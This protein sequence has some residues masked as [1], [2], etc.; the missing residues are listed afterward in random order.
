MITE[1]MRAKSLSLVALSILA[2]VFVAGL[3]SAAILSISNVNVPTSVSQNQGSFSIT[4]NLTNSGEAATISWANSNVSGGSATFSSFSVNSIANG[5]ATPVSEIVTVVVG[6]SPSFTGTISGIIEADPSGSGSSQSFNFSTQVTATQALT[7]TAIC[8]FDSG[9]TSNPDYLD[10]SIR[11]ITVTE[12]FGNDENW[13]PFDE[14]EVEIRV[15]NNGINNYDIDDISLEWGIAPDNLNDDWLFDFDE[16]DEFNLKDDDEDTFTITFKVDG[17]DLDMD[18]EDFAG[19][20]FNLVVRA[21]G[22]I[23]DEDNKLGGVEDTCTADSEAVSIDESN[24]VV[25]TNINVPET[26]QCG[27]T[28]TITADAWN[29]GNNQE[30]EVRVDVFDRNK[31]LIDDLFDLGDIDEFDNAELS[32]DL[33]VPRDAEEKIYTLILRVLDEDSDVYEVGKD[34]DPAEFFVPL[35]VEGG[36]TEAGQVSVTAN[37]VSGGREGQELVVRATVTNNGN[38][39]QTY[40]LNVAGHEDWASSATL[41]RSTLTLAAGQSQDVVATLDVNDNA[42]GSR[43][44]FLELMSDGDLVRQPVNV[45]VSESRGFLGLTGA[46]ITGDNWYLWGIGLLNVL[47]VVVIIVVAVRI[48]RRK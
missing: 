35:T 4:F 26:L 24:A 33:Q 11:D 18:L 40:A 47:L 37:V 45:S 12:G 42:A 25:L 39:Q 44:F 3:A 10:V 14:I 19:N 22:T 15:E 17:D 32:F 30:D 20:D 2:L 28:Y 6:F 46:V 5:S 38:T 41:D 8:A 23:D 36:C 9:V 29:I 48:A 1:K 43:T 13:L 16:V 27:Q 31:E 34:D 21:T 7:E